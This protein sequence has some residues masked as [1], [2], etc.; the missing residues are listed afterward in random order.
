M[1]TTLIEKIYEMLSYVSRKWHL[2]LSQTLTESQG[3]RDLLVADDP[4]KQN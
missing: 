3:K 2:K 1:T 4:Q